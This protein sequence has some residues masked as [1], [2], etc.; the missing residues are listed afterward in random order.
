MKIVD[1][2]TRSTLLLDSSW[3]PITLIT[4]RA[5]FHHFLKD[6]VI[7]L[8]LN[9]NQFKF[10]EW[11]D[12]FYHVEEDDNTEEIEVPVRISKNQPC[13]RSA[14]EV[15][16]LP[17]IVIVTGKFFRNN[18]NREYSFDE[19]C[20]YYKNTCQLCFE[21]FPKNELTKEHVY[22]RSKGGH[23]MNNNITITC[24]RCNCRKNNVTPYYDVSG[25][26]LTG[27]NLPA[28]FLFIEDGLVRDEW[29]QFIWHE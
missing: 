4:A 1:P 15:W 18:R 22:P 23:N 7:A 9:H 20:K 12:G 25:K 13:M 11:V 26:E 21:K 5:C 19:L 10:D 3:L 8:D 2:K 29:N 16:V 6:R 14:S 27:T 28:N 24:R 17:S